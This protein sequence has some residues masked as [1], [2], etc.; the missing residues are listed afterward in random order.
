MPARGIDVML[1]QII[2]NKTLIEGTTD[3]AVVDAPMN[4]QGYDTISVNKKSFFLCPTAVK[5]GCCFAINKPNNTF[6]N[7]TLTAEQVL[8]EK[9]LFMKWYPWGGTVLGTDASSDLQYQLFLIRP[10]NDP[11]KFTFIVVD[12]AHY[13]HIAVNAADHI[14]REGK[15]GDVSFIFEDNGYDFYVKINN[16]VYKS[17]AK[18][19]FDTKGLQGLLLQQVTMNNIDDL[20][21]RKYLNKQNSI[22]RCLEQKQKDMFST[23]VLHTYTYSGKFLDYLKDLYKVDLNIVQTACNHDAFNHVLLLQ[24]AQDV[25]RHS[26]ARVSFAPDKRIQPLL[27]C[28]NKLPTDTGTLY[29]DALCAHY[30][31]ESKWT[32]SAKELEDKMGA[33]YNAVDPSMKVIIQNTLPSS[34]IGGSATGV[35]QAFKHYGSFLKRN[36]GLLKLPLTAAAFVGSWNFAPWLMPLFPTVFLLNIKFSELSQQK[37]WLTG[38]K[39]REL[40]TYNA[41]LG[42]GGIALSYMVIGRDVNFSGATS[43]MINRTP[44]I[45]LQ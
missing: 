13:Y 6:E 35:Q 14:M 21:I 5:K 24:N 27:D 38:P 26:I 3:V 10:D 2:I 39:M 40:L 16:D 36:I 17:N 18:K 45:N 8:T 41:L 25:N 29:A 30:I 32:I 44:R 33:L 7:Y 34:F 20:F 9:W 28:M 4:I 11:H 22:C 37:H 1:A 12:N 19:I 15:P 31:Y 23:R 43:K 42:F